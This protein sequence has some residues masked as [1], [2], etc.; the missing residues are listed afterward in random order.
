MALAALPLLAACGE[1]AS[2]HTGADHS[3]DFHQQ[4]FAAHHPIEA[5]GQAFFKTM[6]ADGD[7][8][9]TREERGSA[10][11]QEFML[12]FSKVDLNGDGELLLDEYLEAL[13]AAHSQPAGQE[14]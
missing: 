5:V 11:H 6:D 12:D 3:D 10:P 8:V 7:G 13:R 1:G 9:V 14:A 2:N 4:M